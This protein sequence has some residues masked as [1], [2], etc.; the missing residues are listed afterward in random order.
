[1]KRYELDAA[2]I[3]SDILVV[4]HALGQKV[5]FEKDKTPHIDNF[6]INQLLDTKEKDFLS[7]LSPIYKTIKLTKNILH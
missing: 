1:M 3:F 2:I 5:V 7:K 6:N 4:P